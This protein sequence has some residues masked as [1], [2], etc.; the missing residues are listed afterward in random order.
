VAAA[1]TARIRITVG[2]TWRNAICQAAV[3]ATALYWTNVASATL[4]CLIASNQVNC[5]P[6]I[7]IVA[8]AISRT[9]CPRGHDGR[10]TAS[11]SSPPAPIRI[12]TSQAGSMP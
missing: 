6:Q 10:N 5:A 1:T 2:R 7:P 8:M 4:E 9:A 3:I 11:S 12:P